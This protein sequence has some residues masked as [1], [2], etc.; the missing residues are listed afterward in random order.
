MQTIHTSQG[1]PYCLRIAAA[2]DNCHR[3]PCK[4]IGNL[5]FAYQCDLPQ[6][7][8]VTQQKIF[9]RQNMSLFQQ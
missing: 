8:L 2:P 6:D 3:S 5:M 7:T 9:L 1:K 4:D